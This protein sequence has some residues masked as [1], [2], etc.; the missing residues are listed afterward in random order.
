M[1]CIHSRSAR[2]C[3]AS[4]ARAAASPDASSLTSSTIELRA[5]IA[6]L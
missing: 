5:G 3:P 1:F 2:A 6:A 4:S